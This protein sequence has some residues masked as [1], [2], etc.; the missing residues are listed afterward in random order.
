MPSEG[1]EAAL[2]ARPHMCL[3]L[4]VQKLYGTRLATRAY[5]I[6]YCEGE[7]RTEGLEGPK[8]PRSEVTPK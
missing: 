2:P 6:Q 5:E 8:V 3:T 4:P 1:A 7:L